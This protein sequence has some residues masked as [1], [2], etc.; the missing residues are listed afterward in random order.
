[1]VTLNI[2][3]NFSNV[4]RQL[5]AMRKDIATKALASALNKTTEQAR[6]EMSRQ[7]RAEFNL[8]PAKVKEKLFVQKARYQ[9]GRFS[10][11]ATL[12]SSAKGGRR[13][14]NVINFQAKQTKKGLTAKIKRNGG[15]VLVSSKGFI[16]NAGRTAFMRLGKERL[17]IKA[18][19]TIDIPAMFTAK[20]INQHVRGFMLRK[21]E[22]IFQREAA[23]Y[24]KR[25]SG[26]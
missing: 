13:S 4:Q 6:S 21:F 11:Y 18:I 22:E 19:S 14:I 3:T 23:F 8:T 25:F 26:R 1:M 15:R 12:S 2:K 9:A 10:L 16:A 24:T 7:I 20:R 5:D 17:P